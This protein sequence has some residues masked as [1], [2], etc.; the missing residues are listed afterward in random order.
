MTSFPSSMPFP[1]FP[2]FPASMTLIAEIQSRNLQ[3]MIDAVQTLFEG[4]QAVAAKSSDPELDKKLMEQFKVPAPGQNP[5]STIDAN[6]DALRTLIK[7]R[8][9]QN[10]VLMEIAATAA[11]SA[12][13]ILVNR[14]DTALGEMKGLFPADS[15]TASK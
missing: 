14:M 2:A 9:G 5:A 7:Y 8:M 13:G 6:I 3:A 11:G 4:M 10:N 1:D 12:S 15:K